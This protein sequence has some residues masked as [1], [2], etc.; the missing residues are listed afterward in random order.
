MSGNILRIIWQKVQDSE[1]DEMVSVI[2]V[3]P[4]IYEFCQNHAQKEII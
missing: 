4:E 3:L 2:S 1:G